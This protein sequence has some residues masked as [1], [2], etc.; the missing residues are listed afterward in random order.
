[1]TR[2][3]E[4]LL[5]QKFDIIFTS[6][7]NLGT[8]TDFCFYPVI[9]G[10]YGCVLPQNHPLANETELDIEQLNHQSFI[11]F[12]EHQSPPTLK[13][14]NRAVIENCP[15]SIYTYGD[16]INTVHTM[17]KSDLGVSVL[18]NFVIGEDHEIAFVPLS[19]TEEVVYGL[20]CLRSNERFEVKRWISTIKELLT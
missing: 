6:E 18:P 17:I 9:Q 12:D 7:D 14:M 19:Y 3:K 10:F 1:M 2:E 16:T 5:N 20:A 13:R 11:L 8:D 15:D 4:D